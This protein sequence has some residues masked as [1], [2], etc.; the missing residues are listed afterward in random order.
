LLNR[1]VRTFSIRNRLVTS[2]QSTTYSTP[3]RS[4]RI[5]FTM[6]IRISFLVEERVQWEEETSTVVVNAH[7]ALILLNHEVTV[8][9][10]LAVSDLGSAEGRKCRVVMLGARTSGMT[11]VAIELLAPYGSFWRVSNPPPDWAAFASTENVRVAVG[12]GKP[13]T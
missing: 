1:N 3:R 6:P 13:K 9:Q 5:W 7:G 8:G 12:V 10:V 11:E 2:S 4:R